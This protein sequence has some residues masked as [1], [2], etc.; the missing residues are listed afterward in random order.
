MV[1][2]PAIKQDI[3]SAVESM[4]QVP[5]PVTHFF[6]P[7]IYVREMFIPAATI[8]IGH[9]QRTQ[10]LCTLVSGIAVFY[11]EDEPPVKIMGPTT[12]LSGKGHKVVYALTD[13]KVQNCYPNPDNIR[14]QD[15]LQKLFVENIGRFDRRLTGPEHG[16][17]KRKIKIDNA[18]DLPPGFE[19]AINI[20]KSN[21]HGKGVFASWPFA[22]GE[23]IAPYELA[24]QNTIIAK[25]LNHSY[26]NNCKVID[27]IDGEK[28]LIAET[29][30][31]GDLGDSKGQELTI[32]YEALTWLGE[33]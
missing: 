21:I 18:V 26:E 14:D 29:P 12:F 4:P 16:E 23:Y 15:E 11:K 25:Y 7:G 32:N 24:G 2:F 31:L 17:P 9:C 3:I 27:L 22:P 1:N 8:A 20:R 33:Q 13:I 19:T 30:I 28:I 10:H 6:A 5:C